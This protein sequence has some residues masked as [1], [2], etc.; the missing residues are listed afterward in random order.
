MPLSRSARC[1]RASAYLCFGRG[2][3]RGT[4][5]RWL[6]ADQYSF[7]THQDNSGRLHVG[8]TGVLHLFDEGLAFF[9][10]EKGFSS[11]T[12]SSAVDHSFTALEANGRRGI[13]WDGQRE[14]LWLSGEGEVHRISFPI[15]E[16]NIV[17]FSTGSVVG[18][19]SSQAKSLLVYDDKLHLF[20]DGDETGYWLRAPLG[21]SSLEF[22]TPIRWTDGDTTAHSIVGASVLCDDYLLL[23]V[24]GLQAGVGLRILDVANG[25]H[26]Q[27]IATPSFSSSISMLVTTQS[28]LGMAGDD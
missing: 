11:A 9:A 24:R 19:G 25:S 28:A 12:S 5:R 13:V 23:P 18:V 20:Y 16:N 17:T 3:Q 10:H 8:T 22:E 21:G 14:H 2:F 6:W 4:A 15:S 27:N 7:Q 26:I 1:T